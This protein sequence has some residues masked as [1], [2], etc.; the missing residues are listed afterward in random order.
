MNFT[1]MNTRTFVSLAAAGA[2]LAVPATG[3]AAKPATKG[4]PAK[5]SAC[6]MKKVAY[7]VGGTFVSATI[8]DPLTTAVNEASVTLKV[9]SANSHVAKSGEIADQD[10]TKEG[11]QVEGATIT[12]SATDAFTLKLNGYVAPDAPAAGDKVKVHGKIAL[13]KKR[14]ALAGTSTAD[15]YGA[16]D[17][18]K[19]TISNREPAPA[20]APAPAA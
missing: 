17:V 2:L 9:T 8:D 7:N 16:V 10:A 5:A 18:R 1:H 4:K 12:I 14:C 3:L 15:R 19:V 6:K 11:V 13:T 20:P